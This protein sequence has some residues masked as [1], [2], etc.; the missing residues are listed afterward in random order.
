MR[1]M[2]PE[3]LTYEPGA[4]PT[5]LRRPAERIKVC[6]VIENWRSMAYTVFHAAKQMMSDMLP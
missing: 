2:N 1:V 6:N 5:A 3:P 4:L